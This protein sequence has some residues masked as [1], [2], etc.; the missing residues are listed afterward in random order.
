VGEAKRRKFVRQMTEMYKEGD[1]GWEVRVLDC[2]TVL[3]ALE[4]GGDLDE[5]TKKILLHY[6]QHVMCDHSP[7]DRP[8]CLFCDTTFSKGRGPLGIML[9]SAAVDAPEKMVASGICRECYR[10]E[11]FEARF[12][13]WCRDKWGA[14]KVIPWS[15]IGAPGRA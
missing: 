15:E 14:T 10:A 1:G 6:L 11:D 2:V 8:L 13:G 3:R 5:R 9:M 4:A 7:A 12:Y